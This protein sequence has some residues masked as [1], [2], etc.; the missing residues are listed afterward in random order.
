MKTLDL[1]AERWPAL[2]SLLDQ[3]LALPA[4]ERGAW[5]D[6]LPIDAAGLR[7]TLQAL[8][9]SHAQIETGNF[10]GTL[11]KFAPSAAASD[12]ALSSDANAGDLVGPYRLL[13][14]LGRGGMGDVWLAERADG[15]LKRPVAL[16]LPRVAWGDALAERLRRERDILATLAH[17]HIARLYDT[18]VDTRGRPYLALEYVEGQPIDVYCRERALPLGERLGLLLQVAAAVAHAHARLVVHRDLKP[19]NIL[20]TADG[21][22]CLLDFGI[23]KL[24]QDDRAAE[25]QLT[26]VSGRMLTLDYASPE[27]IRGEPLGTASDVYSLAVVAYELLTGTRPYRLKRGSAAELE[28]AIAGIDAPLASESAADPG[29]KKQ[30]RGDL[31]AVL[32]QALKKDPAQRYPTVVAFADD[33][34]RH[35]SG[36]AVQALPDSRLYRLRKLLQRHGMAIAVSSAVVV[37]LAAGLGVALWQS[38]EARLQAQRAQR[39]ADRESAVSTLYLETLTTVAG[40]DAATFA[41]PNA[42][43]RAMTHKL[44]ELQQRLQHAPDQQIAL[45][46][47][48]ATQLPYMGDFDGGLAISQRLLR[49]LER[50]GASPEAL[51]TARH[52]AARTLRIANR[53]ADAEA[54]LRAALAAPGMS[55]VPEAV[56]GRALAGLGAALH[57]QGKRREARQ[58]LNEALALLRRQPDPKAQA[59]ALQTLSETYRG[60]DSP[61]ALQ[62]SQQA[63]AALLKVPA[64]DPAYLGAS[65]LYIGAALADAG[66]AGDAESALREAQSRFEPLYGEVHS[67]T[68]KV[69]GRLGLAIAAQGRCDEARQFLAGRYAA[70]QQRPGPDT[71]FAAQTVKTRQLEVELAC[72]DVSAAANFAAASDMSPDALVRAPLDVV[73][74]ETLLRTARGDARAAASLAAQR[75]DT[76][77]PDQQVGGLAFKLRLGLAEAQWALGDRDAAQAAVKALLDLMKREDATVNWTY[78]HATE[79][80]AMVAAMQGHNP[81]AVA[82][83]NELDRRPAEQ[84]IPPF[85]PADRVD[86]AL[87]RAQVWLSAGAPQ[88]ARALLAAV[89]ADLARQHP[90]SPRLASARSLARALGT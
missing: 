35:R 56:R 70:V 53:N 48:A 79:W 24:M 82:M 20:V 66:R 55:S 4:S 72:G 33:I 23:A 16:K 71:P 30:L 28:E 45:M 58:A 25:T 2:S 13:R 43:P 22:V 51:L 40:W 49:T 87:R 65:Y 15:E 81:Q 9:A 84:Q 5:L 63:Q 73:L 6:G 41:K 67:D 39:S 62:A 42:V 21:E 44:E 78:Q 61:G 89:D 50:T 47:V 38:N 75:L 86:S 29:V 32:H 11:P 17:P 83:L 31:D 77:R 36:H 90:H 60:L 57:F 69:A 12:A 54:A 85:T 26:Q 46:D 18:G 64:L 3:A 8:L 27:Q 34:Q 37:A 14:L 1:L 7:D 59:E 80:A 88:Q 74:S 76:M 52:Q 68:V 10:L 19:S